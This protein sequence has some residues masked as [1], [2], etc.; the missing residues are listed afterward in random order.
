[1]ALSTIE[2]VLFLRGVDLFSEIASE[3]LVY[4]ARACREETIPAGTQFITQGDIGDCLYILVSGEAKIEI[5]GVGEVLRRK[6]R[7]I[8]GEMAIISRNPR[9]ATCIATEDITALKINHDDF[10][11]LMDQ[12]PP[13]A[14]GVIKILA[15][16]LDEAAKNI[17]RLARSP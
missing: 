5:N 6:G 8:I 13:L 17:G 15:Q 1:M 2:R 12:H 9:T 10:W 11:E 7:D 16:R 4:V 14:L 3:E